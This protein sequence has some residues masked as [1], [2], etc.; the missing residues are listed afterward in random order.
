MITVRWRNGTIA[1]AA[2][3]AVS[4]VS[5]CLTQTTSAPPGSMIL[6]AGYRHVAEQ[7]IDTLYGRIWKNGGPTIQ[8]EIGGG[9]AD[10]AA[11]IGAN[12]VTATKTSTVRGHDFKVLM[13]TNHRMAIIFQDANFEAERVRTKDDIADIVAMIET[14]SSDRWKELPPRKSP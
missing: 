9:K 7:G 12:S 6:A 11:L 1:L 3:T 4:V 2:A 10:V 14:Y 13:R 8:Y 5:A